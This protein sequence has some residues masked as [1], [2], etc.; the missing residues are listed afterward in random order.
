MADPLIQFADAGASGVV[1]S[2]PP[3]M[4]RG[5]IP[6][7][8]NSDQKLKMTSLPV[9]TDTLRG[10][11]SLPLQNMAV[12]VRLL[13]GEQAAVSSTIQLDPQTAP[14]T[15]NFSLDISG[16]SVAATAHVTEVVDFRMEP[17]EVTLLAGAETSFERT[18]VIENAGNVPL[19][20]G[21]RCEAPL[22]DS[23]DLRTSMLR[24]L[25]D[26]GDAELKEKVNAWMADWG[27]R[28]P[29]MLVILRDPIVLSPGNKITAKATFQLPKN[30]EPFRCYT[31]DL[32]LYNAL[33]SVTIYTTRNVNAGSEK[34]RGNQNGV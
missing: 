12:G 31:A 29:G 17:T 20:L 27:K 4:L 8:N 32:Q 10:P 26:A 21:E 25:H 19:P 5:N 15:Y 23:I 18:F 11:A 16:T 22:V 9:T 28:I 14:G 24:G 33:L 30:L 1:F 13:P 2:G 7:V 3:K 6:L 34:R